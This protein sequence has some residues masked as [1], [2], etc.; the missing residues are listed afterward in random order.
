M[1]PVAQLQNTSLP[2]RIF[3]G[4]RVPDIVATFSRGEILSRMPKLGIFYAF[5]CGLLPEVCQFATDRKRNNLA[6]LA[7]FASHVPSGASV[8]CYQHFA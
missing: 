6:Q 1:A 8:R 4:L 7:V 3:A 2:R 5:L